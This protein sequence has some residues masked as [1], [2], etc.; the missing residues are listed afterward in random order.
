VIRLRAAFMVTAAGAVC[1]MLAGCTPRRFALPSGSSQPLGDGKAIAAEV[2]AGCRGLSTLTA[3]I[4]LS[5]Q[6]GS[7]RV[8]GRL[9]AGL[10][11]PSSI[12]LE[13]VAPFGPP[14][15]ILA[16]DGTNSTLLLPRANRV[17][18]GA[19]P[20]D[21]LRA[22]AGIAL[23]PGDLLALLA[24]CPAVNPAFDD[25]RAY[26]SEWAAIGSGVRTAYVRRVDTSWRL[27]A[28]VGPEI[29]AEYDRFAGRQP[30]SIELREARDDTDR[31]VHLTLALSQVELNAQV[32]QSAFGVAVPA[33]AVPIS[34]DE[35]RESGPMRDTPD[36][37]APRR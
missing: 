15:F 19:A 2:F 32:P 27:A 17:L 12:R 16:A 23:T 26:G 36:R 22:L 8:R 7:E 14:V 10:A 35:L 11:D 24:G 31:R 9:I 5:G 28:I 37:S 4:G 34:L 20:A 33:D 3:E 21:I 18:T 25:G 30:V 13:A 29:T 6:A 1:G